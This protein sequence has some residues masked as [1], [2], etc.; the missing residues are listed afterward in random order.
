VYLTGSVFVKSG[1]EL[2]VD[3]GVELR[4]VQAM[5]TRRRAYWSRT[6]ISSATTMRFV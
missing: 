4:G 5:W 2:R 3:S 1:V 6:A